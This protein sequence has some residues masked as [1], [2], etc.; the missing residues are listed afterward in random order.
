MDYL[1]KDKDV[2]ARRVAIMGHSRLGKTVLWAG[3]QDKRFALV[4]SNCSGRGGASPWRRTYG[5][6]LRSMSRSFPFWFCPNLLNYV[7]KVDKLPVD[8]DELIAL[9]APRPVYITGAQEDQWADPHGM[10]L[11]AV[12]AGPVYKLLGAEGL[13]TDQMP[14]LNQPIVHTIAFHVR[15]GK[16]AVTAFDWDRFLAFADQHLRAH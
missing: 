3:A 9:I 13:G 10:F 12:A 16:H 1:E 15:D 4:L 14:A 11:A 2:D 5:E 8:S 7:D 6:T